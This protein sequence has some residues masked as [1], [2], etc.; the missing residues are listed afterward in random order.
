MESRD[1]RLTLEQLRVAHDVMRRRRR[2]LEK[3]LERTSYEGKPGMKD[4]V[5]EELATVRELERTFDH[6][7]EQ[8]RRIAGNRMR[9]ALGMEAR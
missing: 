2:E 7:Y 3:R 9:E 4:S 5:M 6:N 1:V 8:A